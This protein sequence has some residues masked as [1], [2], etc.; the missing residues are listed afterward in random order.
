MD[1]VEQA[2]RYAGVAATVGL[3]IFL[4]LFISQARDIRR[5]RVWSE[6]EPDAVEEAEQAVVASRGRPRGGEGGC[7]RRGRDDA[8]RR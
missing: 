2:G 7:P 8:E 3:A 6:R 4:P 5:L 1:L